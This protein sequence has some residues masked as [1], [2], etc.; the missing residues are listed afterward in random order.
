MPFNR[1]LLFVFSRVFRKS[2][3]VNVFSY[4]KK[5]TGMSMRFWSNVLVVLRAVSAKSSVTII[6]GFARMLMSFAV[7]VL[8]RMQ[9]LPI[10][11]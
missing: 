10:L 2:V 9:V 6:G 7:I 1:F 8:E 3:T 4:L 5:L 11:L